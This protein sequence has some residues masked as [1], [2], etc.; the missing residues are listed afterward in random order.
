MTLLHVGVFTAQ[1]VQRSQINPRILARCLRIRGIRWE[2]PSFVPQA[3]VVAG[4][5][6]TEGRRLPCPEDG[7]SDGALPT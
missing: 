4:S 2:L 7:M 5:V 6:F 3:V 1:T